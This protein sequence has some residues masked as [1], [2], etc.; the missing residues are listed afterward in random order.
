[1]A[2]SAPEAWLGPM[3][4]LAARPSLMARWWPRYSRFGWLAHGAGFRICRSDEGT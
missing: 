3:A 2:M 1:V 4:A